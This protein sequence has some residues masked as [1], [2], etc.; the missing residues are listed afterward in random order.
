VSFLTINQ[1]F[2]HEARGNHNGQRSKAGDVCEWTSFLKELMM[3]V[4]KA[5]VRD[6]VRMLIAR[7]GK[8]FGT[9]DRTFRDPRVSNRFVIFV[10][11]IDGVGS[12]CSVMLL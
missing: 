7:S 6:V 9:V 3:R 10:G 8:A 5:W 11:N 4:L 1:Q 2:G 12:L